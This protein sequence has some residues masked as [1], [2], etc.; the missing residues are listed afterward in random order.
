MIFPLLIEIHIAGAYMDKF[1]ERLKSVKTWL[2]GLGIG[3]AAYIIWWG[4]KIAIC[5]LTGVCIIF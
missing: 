2:Y 3:G 4:I 5:A 1:I